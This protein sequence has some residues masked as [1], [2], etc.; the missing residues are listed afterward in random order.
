M[1]TS[2]RSLAKAEV[3]YRQLKDVPLARLPR[4]DRGLRL[5]G[6]RAVPAD[7]DLAGH[8]DEAELAGLADREAVADA[9]LGSVKAGTGTKAREAAAA[10]KERL[11]RLVQPAENLL[12]GAEGPSGE[13]RRSA[14][15]SLQ[16]VCLH[17]VRHGDV[18]TA[19]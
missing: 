9:E 4:Q 15:D 1:A 5:A 18:T 6:Q 8:A 13:L 3:N 7:A 10:G 17:L 2:R 11:E 14:A 19:P 12:L 16:L